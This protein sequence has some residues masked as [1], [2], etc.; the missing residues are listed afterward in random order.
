M[1]FYSHQ[2]KD[3][4]T[5]YSA[6]ELENLAVIESVKYFEVYLH[7]QQFR[8]EMDHKAL[9]GLL[10]SKI[11][12]RLLTR[13]AL[14]LKEFQMT[15]AY[16]PGKNNGNANGLSRQVWHTAQDDDEDGGCQTVVRDVDVERDLFMDATSI[17]R[18]GGR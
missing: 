16:K 8:V 1:G 14:F 18:S 6:T 13:W 12:Y 10:T 9:E 11:L 2:L 7:G 3:M 4:E 5:R 15:I 17:S